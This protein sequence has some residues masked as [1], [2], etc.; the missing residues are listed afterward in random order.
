MIPRFKS[1]LVGGAFRK[2]G[3][4]GFYVKIVIMLVTCRNAVLNPVI[5]IHGSSNIVN[6]VRCDLD[7][8]ASLVQS[9]PSWRPND[10]M[11]EITA[12]H[13]VWHIALGIDSTSVIT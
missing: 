5:E 10:I 8:T 13:S 7:K 11:D 12:N 9:N 3:L 1:S 2:V 4:A 6:H